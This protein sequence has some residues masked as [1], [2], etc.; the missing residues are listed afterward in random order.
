VF[1]RF[2]AKQ[3]LDEN[4]QL[5]SIFVKSIATACETGL[6]PIFSE[7]VPAVLGYI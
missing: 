4:E 1:P 5:I 3:T 6:I 2:A 7:G